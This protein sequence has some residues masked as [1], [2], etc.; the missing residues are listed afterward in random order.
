M[1]HQES[2]KKIPLLSKAQSMQL[3]LHA[4]TRNIENNLINVDYLRVE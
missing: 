2:K 3:Y 4:H 1:I